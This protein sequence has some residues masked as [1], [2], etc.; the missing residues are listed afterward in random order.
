MSLSSANS[1]ESSTPVTQLPA[2]TAESGSATN[3]SLPARQAGRDVVVVDEQAESPTLAQPPGPWQAFK[4]RFSTF[5]ERVRAVSVKETF[6]NLLR[7]RPENPV[8]VPPDTT[9]EVEQSDPLQDALIDELDNEE[10]A[11]ASTEHDSDLESVLGPLEGGGSSRSSTT[12]EASQ[13]PVLVDSEAVLQNSEP[14]V[15]STNPEPEVL[16]S[17]EPQLPSDDVGPSELPVESENVTIPNRQEE[18][19]PEPSSEHVLDTPAVEEESE[20]PQVDRD[21]TSPYPRSFQQYTGRAALPRVDNAQ[22]RFRPEGP[23]LPTIPEETSD[24]TPDQPVNNTL[25]MRLKSTMECLKD[26]IERL[27]TQFFDCFR[28][29]RPHREDDNES[30]DGSEVRDDDIES[31]LSVLE[32]FDPDSLEEFEPPWAEEG[33]SSC[34]A[35]RVDGSSATSAMDADARQPSDQRL[36]DVVELNPA[37]LQATMQPAESAGPSSG[38]SAAPV[39]ADSQAT[40]NIRTLPQVRRN[41]ADDGSG[42]NP[43]PSTSRPSQATQNIRTLPQVRRNHADDGSGINPLPSTSRQSV[44]RRHIPKNKIRRFLNALPE[45]LSE[46]VDNTQRAAEAYF[47]DVVRLNQYFDHANTLG[48][49]SRKTYARDTIQ[50]LVERMNAQATV[51]KERSDNM[52]RTLKIGSKEYKNHILDI[53]LTSVLQQVSL[54]QE[55]LEFFI[56]YIQDY[57]NNNDDL[58]ETRS[59]NLD[60]TIKEA[61]GAGVANRVAGALAARMLPDFPHFRLKIDCTYGT[62]LDVLD[63]CLEQPRRAN[64]QR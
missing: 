20:A 8:D 35:E 40:Q 54:D 52:F 12:S 38:L 39:S 27:V 63:R 61:F 23:A 14:Q 19:V 33:L 13:D 41:H 26:V 16:S 32:H 11:D 3:S 17:P 64:H 28:F 24:T 29:S 25:W 45:E 48:W 10:N 22:R 9:D 21:I 58:D 42:I 46:S 2:F 15:L 43:L 57:I 44:N 30:D 49:R 47:A 53:I 56:G 1:M 4:N 7:P 36:N 50:P 51:F 37:T 6:N 60:M 31:I 5:R 55:T 18:Q 59:V 34:L 62:L